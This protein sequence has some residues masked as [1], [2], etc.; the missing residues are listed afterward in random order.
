MRKSHAL[1]LGLALG[2]SVCLIGFYFT[3]TAL[4]SQT[5]IPPKVG[6][7]I[8]LAWF[9]LTII[10]VLF[11]VT[12]LAVVIEFAISGKRQRPGD[13]ANEQE[14][15]LR[16]EEGEGV[17]LKPLRDGENGTEEAPRE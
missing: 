13:A 11:F 17:K 10:L 14:E 7:L 3:V 8:I 16:S 5:V 1:L 12:T 9:I 2:L 15:P 6:A 4:Q